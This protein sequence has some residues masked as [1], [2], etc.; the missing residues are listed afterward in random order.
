MS[1]DSTF[2]IETGFAIR[3]PELVTD[4]LTTIDGHFRAIESLQEIAVT[5]EE[6]ETDNHTRQ[7]MKRFG[8]KFTIAEPEIC[9]DDGFYDDS[10]DDY[11]YNSDD[12]C[13]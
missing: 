1:V 7:E 13:S 5:V 2:T 3:E 11:D 9:S 4:Y 10:L 12:N 6:Y 8:W